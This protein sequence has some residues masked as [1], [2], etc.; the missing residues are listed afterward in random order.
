[1]GTQ[2]KFALVAPAS[3]IKPQLRNLSSSGKRL[4]GVIVGRDLELPLSEIDTKPGVGSKHVLVLPSRSAARLE[5]TA[6]GRRRNSL[7]TPN[8]L[9]LNPA[10][11]AA[12]PRWD[13]PIELILF[14]IDPKHFA[15]TAEEAG[16][17]P[18]LEL[19]MRFQFEDKLLE[20]LLRTLVYQF[21]QKMPADSLYTSLPDPYASPPSGSNPYKHLVTCSPVSR[22]DFRTKSS[23]CH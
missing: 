8:D 23:A 5:W 13:V 1:M 15:A 21:E 10:G 2:T 22:I 3:L 14:A 19:E 12:A 4:S 16:A 6:A 17:R 11:Y 18:S 9:I 20:Q 7:Y